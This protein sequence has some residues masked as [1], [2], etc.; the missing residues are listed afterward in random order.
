M[1]DIVKGRLYVISA[2]S[3]AGKTTLVKRLVEQRPQ[4]RFSISYTTRPRRP[5]EQEGRDY[6]FVDQA[7]FNALREAGEFLEFAS[8]FGNCYATSRSQVQELIDQGH[9]VLLEI[10][11]QGAQ[12]VRRNLPEC[13]SIFVLPPSLAEL[14]RRLRTRG[15]DVDEV[16]ARRLGEARDDLSHW[17]EFD[18]AVINDDLESAVAAVG[19]ILDGTGAGLA[20]ADPGHRT[21]IEAALATDG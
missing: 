5:G 21:R 13:L 16:I 17:Q 2:P 3:G 7:R 19:S 12:Q 14:E 11:W 9:D 15:T 8:V 1:N 18:Y 10:D 6:F 20:T 4:L